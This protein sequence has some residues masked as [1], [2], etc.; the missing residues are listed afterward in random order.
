MPVMI[1]H[2]Q[3]GA[4]YSNVEAAS[5]DAYKGTKN[6]FSAP[7]P[8]PM[9]VPAACQRWGDAPALNWTRKLR[10]RVSERAGRF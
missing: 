9:S 5:G 4:E 8:D 1:V 6:I 3:P 10:R 7:T 2:C